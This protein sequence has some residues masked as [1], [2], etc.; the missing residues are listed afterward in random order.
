MM[1]RQRWLACAATGALLVALCCAL[2]ACG[3]SGSSGGS[4]GGG[5]ITVG[6][7]VPLSGAGPQY[8]EVLA[9]AKAAVRGINARGGVNGKKLKLVSCDDQNNPNQG[10]AC[11]KQMVQD[12][13]AALVDNYGNFGPQETPILAAAG[14]PEIGESSVYS[15]VQYKSPNMYMLD[16]GDI[17][18]FL[19]PAVY[20]HQQ[21]HLNNFGCVA[22]AVSIAAAECNIVKGAVAK[23]GAQWVGSKSIP[24]TVSDF[25]PYPAAM[26]SAK[27]DFVTMVDAA[28]ATTQYALSAEQQ[29][30]TFR[31]SSSA[32]AVTQ[33]DLTTLDLKTQFG[34]NTLFG[35]PVPPE[36]AVSSYPVLGTFKKDLAAEA[37]SGDANAAP[38]KYSLGQ[39][40]E[41]FA[42][43]AFQQVGNQTHMPM[44]SAS[45]VTKALN[46]AKNIKVGLI[47]PWTPNKQGPAGF[48]S[49]SSPYGYAVRPDAEGN[50]VLADPKPI[51]ILQYLS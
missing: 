37:A 15:A 9:G 32:L 23:F 24:V 33:H 36:S 14:I 39:E 40:Q 13:V 6:T 30:A 12:H 44:T 7:I 21:L 2:S 35:S 3:S 27:A 38:S 19:P 34:R 46:G 43:Y 51:D 26:T 31:L 10:I 17:T 45:D 18:Q 16:P 4:N 49:V 11:A 5:T 42:F 8:P 22:A 25:S 41:W 48:E 28:E 50:Y 1:N 29:G 20:A 47:P